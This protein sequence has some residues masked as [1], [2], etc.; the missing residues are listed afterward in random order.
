MYVLKNLCHLLHYIIMIIRGLKANLSV[1]VWL[2][3]DLNFVYEKA[4]LW[5]RNESMAIPRVHAV[6]WQTCRIKIEK[7]TRFIFEHLTHAWKIHSRGFY[8]NSRW[9]VPVPSF[10]WKHWL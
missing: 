8:S 5:Q 10:K 1:W 7:T 2:R 9:N 6:K 3:F 4:L